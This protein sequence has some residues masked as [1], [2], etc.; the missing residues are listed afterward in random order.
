MSVVLR[1]PASGP[2]LGRIGFA[3]S[4]AMEAALSLRV[5]TDPKRYPMH[6]PW[7][8][9]PGTCPTTCARRSAPCRSA[10]GPSCRACSRSA[11]RATSPRSR[12]NSSASAFDHDSVLYELTLPFV[13]RR[14]PCGRAIDCDE[15]NPSV[16]HR[17]RSSTL[18]FGGAPCGRRLPRRFQEEVLACARDNDPAAADVLAQAFDDP[19]SIRHRLADLLERYWQEAFADEWT[20]IRPRLD[21]EVTDMARALVG[22]GLGRLLSE[23]LPEAHHD[24]D[25]P[26]IVLDKPF[27]RDVDVVE[28][29]GLALVPTTFEHRVLV[30]ADP[31][32]QLAIILPTRS[33]R[34]V[35]VPQASDREVATGMRALG[36]ETRLQILRLIAEAPRST[37]ELA[38]LL[39][40]SESAVSR[41]LKVLASVDVVDST[42]DGYYVLYRLKADR[43]A[44]L[45]G[46]LRRTLGLA[47][48]ASGSTPSVPV[49]VPRTEELA[50]RPGLASLDA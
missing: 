13:G 45:G 6:L 33:M 25:I 2:L 30:E 3:Y 20:R 11:C 16:I 47:P 18:P 42:R 24:L 19:A 14:A 48:T 46:A 15:P 5:V 43:I 49:V 29:G 32:W 31:P 35:E 36:D 41:H 8:R 22:G 27:D 40:L 1:L 10:S 34:Q 17:P 50:S 12:T 39:S 44:A 26:A 7:A 23:F 38:T 21:A 37:K 4:P 9:R 28:R